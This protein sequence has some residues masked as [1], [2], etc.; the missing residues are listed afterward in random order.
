[1]QLL[2]MENAYIEP[3]KNKASFVADSVKKAYL[4]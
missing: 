4:S 2:K 3:K 1:M